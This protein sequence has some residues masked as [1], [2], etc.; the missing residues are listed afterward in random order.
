[1]RSMIFDYEKLK[2]VLEEERRYF[3]EVSSSEEKSHSER[4]KELEAMRNR[5]ERE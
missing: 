4:L 2:R 5:L 3:K 1:M